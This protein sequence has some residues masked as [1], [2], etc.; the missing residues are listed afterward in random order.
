MPRWDPHAPQ[1][2]IDAALTLFAEHGYDD[3]TVLDIAQRAGLTKST[4]FRYF[5][6]K[7]DVLFGEDALTERLVSAI[8]AAPATATP[9]ESV[10]GALEAL[11]QEVFT[12]D[13]RTFAA[14]RRAVIDTHPD[15]QE[16]EALKAIKLSASIT[17]A[18]ERRG[19]PALTARITAELGMLLLKITYEQ[20]SDQGDDATCA[21]EYSEVA[22]HVLGELRTV[23]SASY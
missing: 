12:S 21:Q 3:T 10:A 9:F 19:T 16:R 11:G 5:P 17:D 6:N 8:A 22:R 2:L 15:L 18:I 20:W 13:Y 7:R 4:F 1:R 23:L 14:R